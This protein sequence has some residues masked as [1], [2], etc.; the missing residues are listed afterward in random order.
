M[1]VRNSRS[2]DKPDK[3]QNRGKYTDGRVYYDGVEYRGKKR[4]ERGLLVPSA[5]DCNVT[6]KPSRRR[7]H[8]YEKKGGE[9]EE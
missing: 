1:P 2:S 5:D 7:K 3:R 6:P 9:K 4:V 8:I